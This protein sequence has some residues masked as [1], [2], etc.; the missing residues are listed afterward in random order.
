MDNN[1]YVAA[2]NKWLEDPVN[3]QRFESDPT[4]V[5]FQQELDRVKDNEDNQASTLGKTQ[6]IAELANTISDQAPQD[7][8]EAP[9]HAIGSAVQKVTTHPPNEKSASQA[10]G[11]AGTTL[12]SGHTLVG[13]TKADL[14]FRS[15][16][17]PV[18]LVVNLL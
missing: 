9:K 10:M 17:S 12:G 14:D 5:A 18:V 8:T 1:D 4:Y 6:D 11:S 3:R 15:N 16:R 7:T 2:L 13:I